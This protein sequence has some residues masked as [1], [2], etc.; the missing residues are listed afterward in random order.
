MSPP[1]AVPIDLGGAEHIPA[2]GGSLPPSPGA[3]GTVGYL[4]PEREL[5]EYGLPSDIWAMGVVG[6]EL[7]YGRHPWRF[8]SLNPFRP[9]PAFESSRPAFH[10]AYESAMRVLNAGGPVE[11]NQLDRTWIMNS[12]CLWFDGLPS[13]PCRNSFDLFSR[14]CCAMRGR[15]RTTQNGS[16]LMVL[17]RGLRSGV[18]HGPDNA[19]D[20]ILFRTCMLAA[21]A[22][23]PSSC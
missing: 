6:Y 22:C 18:R 1:R 3:G 13:L 14:R 20:V 10:K 11:P 12:S 19:R 2:A 15:Q 9:G 8:F 7:S 4:S 16:A 23:H 21:V 17:V 5:E